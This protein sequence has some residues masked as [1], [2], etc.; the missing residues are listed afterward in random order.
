M[1]QSAPSTAPR[2]P[3]VDGLRGIAILAVLQTHLFVDLTPSG[4]GSIGLFTYQDLVIPICPL[5]LA[6]GW[7]GVNLFF[8]LSG[9]VLSLPYA[10]KRRR[11]ETWDDAKAF[12]R[13]RARRLMPLYYFTV[14]IAWMFVNPLPRG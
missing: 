6:H 3:V 13:H 2:I 10:E 9:F 1:K 11:I 12:W 5:P 7:M 14:V 8:V 4:W